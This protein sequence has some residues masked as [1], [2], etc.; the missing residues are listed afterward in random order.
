MSRRYLSNRAYGND[1]WRIQEWSV[2]ILILL[3]TL[4]ALSSE[5]AMRSDIKQ[6]QLV[7]L[8]T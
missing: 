1:K 5:K 8:P 7:A 3:N 6:R 2:S 4:K